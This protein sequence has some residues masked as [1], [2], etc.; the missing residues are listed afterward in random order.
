MKTKL[1]SITICL[2]IISPI[3]VLGIDGIIDYLSVGKQLDFNKETYHLAWSSKPSEIYYKQ[4]YL[5]KGETPQHYHKMILVEAIAANLP[6]EKALKVKVQ[7]LNARKTWDYV[8]NYQVF[9]NKDKPEEGMIDFVMSDTMYTYEWN[10]YRYQ[11]QTGVNKQKYLVLMAYSY[12][13]SLNNDDDLKRFFGHI[14][15]NRLQLL[16]QLQAY[17]IPKVNPV[18]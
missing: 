5:L 2:L 12:R 15:S 6:I 13:D 18:K 10:L 9:E 14:K 11:L 4:E 7:E 17:P 3:L 1:H 8:A 16:D